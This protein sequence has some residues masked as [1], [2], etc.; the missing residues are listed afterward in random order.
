LDKRIPGLDGLRAL[1]AVGV[2][3]LHLNII[4]AGWIGVQVFYVLSGFLITGILLESKNHSESLSACLKRFYYRRSLRIL[5]LYIVYL[6]LILAAS[7]LLPGAADLRA[8]LP[9]LVTYTNNFYR[10]FHPENAIQLSSHL[11]TLSVEEQFYIAWP[12]VVFFLSKRH[13]RAFALTIV[14]ISPL[15]RASLLF[16]SHN[17]YTAAYFLT[18]FQL[19]SFAAGAFLA[20]LSARRVSSL[21]PPLLLLVLCATA[22][23]LIWN[24]HQPCFGLAWLMSNGHATW[25]W[26]Y[27]LINLC[28]A[29]LIMECISGSPII[30]FLEWSPLR[31]LGRI[32]Y[33]FYIWHIA[34]VL[35]TGHIFDHLHL[36]SWHQ[37]LSLLLLA[38]FFAFTTLISAFTFHFL[39]LPLMRFKDRLFSTTAGHALTRHTQTDPASVSVDT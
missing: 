18:P 38:G 16:A 32:S 30:S 3:M 12:L 13:L 37:P 4:R 31:Y 27:T 34:G 22:L 8:I 2:A 39:E 36:V 10:V 29:V 35:I 20:T 24:R 11:W 15:L 6:I 23:A 19:D 7:Y 17:P 21:R 25:V 14:A 1:S 5:P 9:S 33:G 28:A 26:G